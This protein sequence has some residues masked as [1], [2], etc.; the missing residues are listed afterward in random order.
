MTAMAMSHPL[1]IPRPWC[2]SSEAAEGV[3]KTPTQRTNQAQGGIPIFQVRLLLPSL[4]YPI[5]TFAITM[6]KESRSETW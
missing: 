5:P 4:S 3:S 2:W 6:E 1:A